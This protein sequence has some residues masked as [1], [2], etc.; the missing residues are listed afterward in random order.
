M[1]SAGTAPSGI[2]ASERARRVMT[3]VHTALFAGVGIYA[4][5]LLFLRS[6]MA[7]A[8][9]ARPAGAPLFLALAA[10]GAAQYGAAA[11]VG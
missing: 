2:D 6:E 3:V 1:Q 7:L 8:A 4:V 10:I 5:V 11:A 9:A